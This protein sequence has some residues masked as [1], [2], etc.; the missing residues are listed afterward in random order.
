M[1]V[2]HACIAC[3]YGMYVWY[4]CMVCMYVLHVCIACM[5]YVCMVCMACMYGV[6]V[7][8]HVADLPGGN[9]RKK[10]IFQ[11]KTLKTYILAQCP[12]NTH[13]I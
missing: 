11:S 12:P 9:F 8:I 10:T 6:Y 7:W 13:P 5:Y 4:V 3:M 2:F 1:Y